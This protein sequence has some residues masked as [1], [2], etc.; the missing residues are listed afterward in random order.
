MDQQP[1]DVTV[2][3]PRHG[4]EPVDR[5]PVG[6]RQQRG[7]QFGVRRCQ[8]D[9]LGTRAVPGAQVRG[10]R[11]HLDRGPKIEGGFGTSYPYG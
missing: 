10:R 11:D 8:H 9:R 3:A 2:S 1:V 6:H 4:S 7:Q 5:R